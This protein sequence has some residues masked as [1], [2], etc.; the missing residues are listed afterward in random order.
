MAKV[1]SISFLKDVFGC[2]ECLGKKVNAKVDSIS[3][4]EGVLNCWVCWGKK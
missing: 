4:L 1:E 3:F 2:W